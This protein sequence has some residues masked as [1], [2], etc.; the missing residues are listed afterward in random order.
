MNRI[1]Y[2]GALVGAALALALAAPAEAGKVYSW[3]TDDGGYAFADDL[4]RVP[5]RYR[6]RVEMRETRSVREFERFTP[7]DDVA[8]DAYA[9]GLEK[10][11]EGLRA[12]QEHLRRVL[13]APTGQRAADDTVTV[14]LSSNGE[15]I[16][17]IPQGATG[18]ADPVVIEKIIAKP[19][20]DIRT[21][22]NTVIR[23]GDETIA[24]VRPY[25][26]VPTLRYPT[27]SELEG[28]D[29]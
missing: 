19:D 17:D 1:H 4:R 15:P 25:D 8:T 23:Q 28:D 9:A 13:A 24:I 20:N 14:R 27:E 2:S 21:R 26:A 7:T 29:F 6:D 16:I 3:R 18:G 5:E 12:R 22:S 10:R 11:L